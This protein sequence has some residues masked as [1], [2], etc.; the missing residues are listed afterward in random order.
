MSGAAPHPGDDVDAASAEI[1]RAE[2]SVTA[3]LGSS[4]GE[5]AMANGAHAEGLPP[6]SAPAEPPPRPVTE[7]KGE[8]PVPTQSADSAMKSDKQTQCKNVCDALTSMM[9]A[10]THLCDI[11]G[12]DDA[13]CAS[14]RGRAERAEERVTQSCPDCSS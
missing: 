13:R 1:D 14:A 7:P 3:L 9:R 4:G 5:V 10:V 12:T 11:T 2:T 8:K 6:P